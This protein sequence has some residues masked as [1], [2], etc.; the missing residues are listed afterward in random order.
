M[1]E[2]LYMKFGGLKQGL[3]NF[4]IIYSVVAIVLGLAIGIAMYSSI[5]NEYVEIED[6]EECYMGYAGIFHDCWMH[7]HYAT[8]SEYI[9][10]NSHFIGP[11]VV[12]AVSILPVSL[13]AWLITTLVS[14]SKTMA[15]K[16]TLDGDTITVGKRVIYLASVSKVEHGT[17]KTRMGDGTIL[18]HMHGKYQGLVYPRKRSADAA[19]VAA[20]LERKVAE[21]LEREKVEYRMRCNVCGS[22]FC[23]K[24]A[25][26]RRNVEYANRAKS[27][28]NMAML[29]AIG[30]TQLGMYSEFKDADRY[31]DK[32]VD[33][34]KCPQCHSSDLTEITDG[35]P[36]QAPAAN[37][38]AA[39]ASAADELKKFKDLLDSG[40]ISQEEFEAKKKQL[41]GQ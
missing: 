16:W 28:A 9:S 41:L 7:A 2:K 27:S 31:I 12:A 18:L 23:Y 5:A 34:S 17:P 37:R 20:Y 39:V 26:L 15:T 1:E 13:I 3:R 19:R 40:V 10:G 30:G 35:E 6:C 4:I 36:V 38:P 25:D 29:N 32:I 8:R 33:Y 24:L 14:S 22:V 11:P 21:N